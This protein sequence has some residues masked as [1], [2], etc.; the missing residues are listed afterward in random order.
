MRFQTDV[1]HG[2]YECRIQVALTQPY[3]AISK[4][5]CIRTFA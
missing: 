4:Y 5:I 2:T 1:Q 3:Y